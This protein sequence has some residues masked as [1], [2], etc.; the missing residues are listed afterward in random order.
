VTVDATDSL[1]YCIYITTNAGVVSDNLL[2]PLN[3]TSNIGS[4]GTNTGFGVRNLDTS[5]MHEYTVSSNTI[6]DGGAIP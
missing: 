6:A 5:D 1:G 2:T 4:G 3:N